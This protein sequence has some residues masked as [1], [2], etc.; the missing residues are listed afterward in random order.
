MEAQ[1]T[2]ILSSLGVGGALAALIFWYYREDRKRSE[3][4]ISELGRDFKQ[5]V[6]G[7]TA[8]MTK[9][10]VLIEQKVPESADIDPHPTPTRSSRAVG[11]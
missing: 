7:N 6:E 10:T 3:D 5:T 4:R 9:L 2:Q 1:L 8:V 11:R